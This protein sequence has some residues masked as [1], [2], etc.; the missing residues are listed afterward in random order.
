MTERFFLTF[1]FFQAS[2]EEKMTRLGVYIENVSDCFPTD[3]R[4]NLPTDIF[5]RKR[6]LHQTSNDIHVFYTGF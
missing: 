5:G 6:L 1:L 3:L 4:L 2:H